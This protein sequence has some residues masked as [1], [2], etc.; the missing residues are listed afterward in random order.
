LP[1]SESGRNPLR[2]RGFQVGFL[3]AAALVLLR[4]AVGWH[5]LY[6]GIWKLQTPNFSAAGFLS[7]AKGPLAD[8]FYAL[9]PDID[10]RE[11]LDFAAHQAQ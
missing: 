10:G 2:R 3:G 6:S 9:V 8:R 7:Q 1:R 5:F 4:V 11:H